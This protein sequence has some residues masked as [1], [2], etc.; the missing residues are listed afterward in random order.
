MINAAVIENGVV[1]NV[2]YIDAENMALFQTRGM[3]LIDSEPL[4]LSIGDITPDGAAFF[5]D[6]V[7]LPLPV[8]DE[9]A[10]MQAALEL[11]DVHPEGDGT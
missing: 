11:L 1:V 10:D 7:Q 6:G 8:I 9:T 4:G 5:R 2:I 3:Q